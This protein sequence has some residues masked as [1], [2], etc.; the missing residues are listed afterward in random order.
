MSVI[1]SIAPQF[2]LYNHCCR[3]NFDALHTLVKDDLL[4][5]NSTI[6][7]KMQSSIEL[8]PQIAGHIVTSGGKRL[9]PMLTLASAGLVGYEGTRHIDLAACVEFIHTATL[10][11]DDVVDQS[12][13]RRGQGTANAVWG[14]QASVLVGDFLLSRA[15]QIMVAD[16]SLKVLKILSDASAVIAEGEVHQTIIKNDLETAETAYFQIIENKTAVL[17]A[18]AAQIGAVIAERPEREERALEAFGRNLGV[19]FQLTDDVLDYSAEQLIRGDDFRDGKITLP[20]I[21]AYAAGNDEERA[22]WRRTIGD[23]KQNEEDLTHAQSLMLH[24][25]TLSKTLKRAREYANAAHRNL[26]LFAPTAHRIAMNEV[27]DFCVDRVY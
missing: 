2:G 19:A 25:G 26:S 15:F 9:R 13:L 10:L 7:S 20:V 12:N 17:F 21:L 18:A 6:I 27:I 11:H 4:D 24:H 14:N 16:G 5:V 23:L 8:I 3:S 1:T 22:F